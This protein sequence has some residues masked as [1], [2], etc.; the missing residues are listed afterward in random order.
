M[1]LPGLMLVL[2]SVFVMLKSTVALAI[3]VGS[4]PELLVV[5]ISLPLETEAVLITLDGALAA[6]LTVRLIAG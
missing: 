5:L 3:V 4:L 2:P 1:G 6:T